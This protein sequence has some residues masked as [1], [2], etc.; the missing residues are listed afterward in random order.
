MSTHEMKHA[1]HRP[2]PILRRHVGLVRRRPVRGV[3]SGGKHSASARCG[4]TSHQFRKGCCA[5]AHDG[6]LASGKM[7]SELRVRIPVT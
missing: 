7:L 6:I 5:P 3:V 4:E 2:V 1:A